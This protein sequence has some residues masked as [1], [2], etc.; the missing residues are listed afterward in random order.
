MSNY[1]KQWSTATPGYLIFLIDQSS[2]M[3]R[4]WRDGKTYALYTAE[5]INRT[6]S[7]LIATNA[8]GESVKNRVFISLIS[9]SGNKIDDVRSD[10]LNAYAEEPLRIDKKIKKVSDGEGGFLEMEVQSP[11]FI[12]PFG[13]GTTP[14]SGGFKFAKKLIDSWVELKNDCPVP[15]IINVSD[16]MPDG[17][18]KEKTEIEIIDTINAANDIMNIETNDGSPLIFNVH[19]ASGKN[20]IQFPVSTNDLGDDT[21]A[22]FLF[23]ISSRV[24]DVYLKAAKDMD[25]RDVKAN[26]KGFISNASPETLIKF[27]NFGSSGGINRATI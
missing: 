27:I 20:E 26:S 23:K 5:I 4:D 7:E 3:A 2:S 13:Q 18:N 1:S 8:A 12:E 21:I 16:G 6:I 14:M 22:E 19:I 11:V 9:Y 15:V 25:L 24:P 17:G 10:Y